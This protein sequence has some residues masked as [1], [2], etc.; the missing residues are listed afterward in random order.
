MNDDT[1]NVKVRVNIT[2]ILQGAVNNSSLEIST[3]AFKTTVTKDEKSESEVQIDVNS[4]R[5][6]FVVKLDSICTQIL[7]CFLFQN[8][9]DVNHS[10]IHVVN[11]CLGF[12]SITTETPRS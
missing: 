6:L 12:V 3:F 10:L 7:R 8:L 9:I 5:L 2:R 4:G 1:D 11:P